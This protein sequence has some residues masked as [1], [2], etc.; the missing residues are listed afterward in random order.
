MKVFAGINFLQRISPTDFFSCATMKV[1]FVFL[2][3]TIIWRIVMKFGTD[4]NAPLR[5]NFNN[6]DDPLRSKFYI[7]KTVAKLMTFPFLFCAY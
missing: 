5:M 7:G 6:V 1:P 2:S 4:I 3:D